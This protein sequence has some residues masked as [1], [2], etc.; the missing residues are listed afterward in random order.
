MA[1]VP[2]QLGSLISK[3]RTETPGSPLSERR[4]RPRRERRR[5]QIT[6]PEV[7][8]TALVVRSSQPL[9]T[10]GSQD[11]QTTLLRSQL[12]S[13]RG[14]ME[15]LRQLRQ[16]QNINFRFAGNQF[17]IEIVDVLQTLSD[18]P[19]VQAILDTSSPMDVVHTVEDLDAIDN[20][21]QLAITNQGD[22]SI[23]P[24]QAV[25]N[26]M[27][28]LA[29]RN[30]KR[31]RP[32]ITIGEL[33]QVR[34]TEPAQKRRLALPET[35]RALVSLQ[36]TAATGPMA[37]VVAQ[38]TA[39]VPFQPTPMALVSPQLN[40]PLP[41]RIS[42]PIPLRPAPLLPR[43][44]P[45]IAAA[46]A[47]RSLPAVRGVPALVFPAIAA[48][49]PPAV[50]Q[51]PLPAP[52]GGDPREA[53]A[54]I[55]GFMFSG[56]AAAGFDPLVTIGAG[57]LLTRQEGSLTAT[58]PDQF[59]ELFNRLRAIGI[60]LKSNR[61][62]QNNN[63]TLWRLTVRSGGNGGSAAQF[64]QN[65]TR[66]KAEQ[67]K[68]IAARHETVRSIS[69][70]KALNRASAAVRRGG[71]GI[72]TRSFGGR[73]FRFRRTKR[74]TLTGLGKRRRSGRRGRRRGGGRRRRRSRR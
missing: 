11:V 35:S 7:T 56:A 18:Q 38:P 15:M 23:V 10:L 71:G 44:A 1:L 72:E 62:E 63:R 16:G 30:L 12:R 25:V 31:A 20:N 41:Q 33:S 5:L 74:G 67:Q 24:I 36:P 73:T 22:R 40:Q 32:G 50:L 60:A 43:P 28:E 47:V 39:L 26:D 13:M 55:E 29:A 17:K 14:A 51:L 64:E 37:I 49:Q 2:R 42:I 3:I 6:G 61:Q 59:N 8:S 52:M 68:L 66:L 57:G 45:L 69:V 9:S 21:L 48:A 70:S 65:D 19:V 34:I 54:I 27:M 53:Q 4:I 46:P 58:T